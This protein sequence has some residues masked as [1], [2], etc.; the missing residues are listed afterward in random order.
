MTFSAPELSKEEVFAVKLLTFFSLPSE[1]QFSISWNPGPIFCKERPDKNPG[2]NFLLG[3]VHVFRE[4]TR[5]IFDQADRDTGARLE[6][7]YSRF[8]EA[9]IACSNP[10]WSFAAL[11]H[12]PFWE[13]IRNETR[14]IMDRLKVRPILLKKVLVFPDFIE[15]ERYK[16]D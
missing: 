12:D 13:V 9:A 4:Y 8:N 11:Q 5:M 1:Q 2:A 16:F 7:L 10:P 3:M 15:V 6:V 14:V